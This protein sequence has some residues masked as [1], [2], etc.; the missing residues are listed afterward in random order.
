MRALKDMVLWGFV[1]LWSPCRN[2]VRSLFGRSHAVII[3]YHRV[4]DAHRD[5][6]SVGE[7]QFRRQMRILKRRC[8][9]Q[10]MHSFLEARGEKRRRTVALV[11]F[12]DGYDDN[13]E[14]AKHL[15]EVGLP[16]TFFVTTRKVGTEEGFAHDLK[17]LGRAVPTLSWDRVREMRKWGF[18]IGNHTATHPRLSTLDTDEALGEIASGMEDLRREVGANCG[19]RWFAYPHGRPEDISDEVRRRLPEIGVEC[20][21]SAYGGTCPP[22]FDRFDIRRQGVHHAFSDL[23]FKALVEGWRVRS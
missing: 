5:T 19:E 16:C 20:C 9:V 21:F 13:Y 11:T 10:D 4:N 12:D 18:G 17:K 6:V 8:R 7:E 22:D 14:A 3:N 1:Y 2:A 15:R 23:Y